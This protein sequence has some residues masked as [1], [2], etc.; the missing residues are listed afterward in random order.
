MRRNP[1]RPGAGH[2]AN[3][4]L[5]SSPRSPHHHIAAASQ[6][7]CKRSVARRRRRHTSVSAF[8]A[9]AAIL[10]SSVLVS[11]PA[12]I[13]PVGASYIP[14]DTTTTSPASVYQPSFAADQEPKQP[15]L[16]YSGLASGSKS[17]TSNNG[18]HPSYSAQSAS[19][20]PAIS[21]SRDHSAS[22]ID[23]VDD[24]LP[25][26]LDEPTLHRQYT[27]QYDDES[28]LFGE[29]DV[30]METHQ[31]QLDTDPSAAYSHAT[32][33][34]HR[35][36]LPST[37]PSSIAS[38]WSRPERSVWFQQKAIIITSIFL[39]IFI[40][41]FI[42][43]A[44][45]LRER[46]FDDELSGLDDEEALARIEE[47]MTMGRFSD[48]SE[49]E[50]ESPSA[51]IKRRL[52]LG[53]KP[54]EKDGSDSLD[55]STG[56]SSAVKRKRHLVSRWTRTN[57][58]DSNDTMRGNS[59]TAS[60]RSGR[61]TR[62]AV[63]G[64]PR[65]QESVEITYDSEGAEVLRNN[66]ETDDVMQRDG[67][68]GSAAGSTTV[69]DDDVRANR[70]PRSPP[71]PHPDS[72]ER[73]AD[74]SSS[75]GRSSS[76]PD[77][78]GSST[79][80]PDA[81]LRSPRRVLLDDSDFQAADAAEGHHDDMRHMPPAYIPSGGSGGMSGSSYDGA[82]L[83]AAISRGDAKHGIPPPQERD[84]TV[85]PEVIGA[86]LAAAPA[87]SRN[88]YDEPSGP[89]AAHI[90]T[91]DKA[92]LGALSA[93][94]SMPS[95]PAVDTDTSAPAYGA[96]EDSAAGESSNSDVQATAS[97]ASGPSAPALEVDG[98]GFEVAPADADTAA[99]GS[100]PRRSMD[101]DD[102]RANKGKGKQ[103]QT[104]S[105]LPAPPTAVETAF[106]PFDQPYRATSPPG[107][108]VPLSTPG[109]VSP[110]ATMTPR[111]SEK[112]K[113][114]EEEQ[115]AHLVASRPETMAVPRY[116]RNG[117]SAPPLAETEGG[118]EAPRSTE[119]LPAYEQRRRSSAAA[120]AAATARLGLTTAPM[121][122]APQAP[123]A[124]VAPSAPS[125]PSAPPMHDED[126]GVET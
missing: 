71:P 10:V 38:S 88:T 111:K 82:A 67:S 120:T 50:T 5:A 83:A 56:S 117:P 115:L 78:H 107:S 8:A 102:H 92:L 60:I 41:L 12:M 32:V 126:D 45:F 7:P 68:T 24:H 113:E 39:A 121:A 123:T 124:S 99:S 59:D 27:R 97:A 65:A 95:A 74:T 87:A 14:T 110:T 53:R 76:N 9:T 43:A 34:A 58:R 31:L 94:A 19:Q 25:Q 11:S 37:Y 66:V 13:A 91:D 61:S 48:P 17:T 125:A 16:A 26:H 116:E 29:R 80:D 112:Q 73:L 90:A 54:S 101:K 52:G 106:S 42:G 105:L 46:K 109:R 20:H 93:A 75:E 69:I 44:V 36:S 103:P 28:A 77:T 6:I 23:D 3:N 57:L 2:G 81:S 64:D 22:S 51:K 72:A 62:R 86:V 55:P 63:L 35:Y 114:A 104:P 122:S 40:V 18:S 49:K 100:T 70:R 1:I 96:P 85:S 89:T 119:H 98:E 21:S 84:S 30:S 4:R 15:S 47:R 79:V 33:S 118:V 108:T